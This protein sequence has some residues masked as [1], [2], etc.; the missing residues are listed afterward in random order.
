MCKHDITRG[1]LGFPWTPSDQPTLYDEISAN[2]SIGEESNEVEEDAFSSENEI[3]GSDETDI[4]TEVVRSLVISDGHNIGNGYGLD[5]DGTI[6]RVGAA[7]GTSLIEDEGMVELGRGHCV[8]TGSK[9]Y[10]GE[11]EGH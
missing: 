11:W 1:P 6:V 8:K 7:E 10:G 4:P 3:D 9:R 2:H 5:N